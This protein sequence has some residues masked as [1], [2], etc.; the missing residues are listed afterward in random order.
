MLTNAGD[1]TPYYIAI[2]HRNAIETWSATGQAFSGSVLS[3]DFTTA[4]SQAY[5]NNEIHKGT[6][7]CIFSGDPTH[8]GIV[9]LSD[10]VVIDNDSYNFV[11]GYVV[12]DINGDHV[13]DLSDMVIV[14]NN[15]FTFVAT[16]NPTLGKGAVSNPKSGIQS[17]KPTLK[18]AP[19]K[20]A[21]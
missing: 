6:K 18:G 9:D 10:M 19:V 4:A 11:T 12:S 17:A 15:S 7:Y 20:A 8:D 14:D 2:K 13:V 16:K 21:D 1:G 3:Y 5:G